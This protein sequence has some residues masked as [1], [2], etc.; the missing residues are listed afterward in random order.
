MIRTPAVAGRFYPGDVDSLMDEVE[1]Y[2]RRNV[3]KSH[4]LGVVAPHAGFMYSGGVAGAVYSRVEIP[5]T[6]ILLG[7]N[8]TGDGPRVSLMSEGSWS[9]PFGSVAIDT[10]LAHEILRVSPMIRHD[11]SAHIYEH[12]LETQIPFM[13][14]FRRDF[15]IVPICLMRVGYEVCEEVSR[16]IVRA[17]TALKRSSVLIV[18]SSDMTHYE[19]HKSASKKDRVAIDLI[20][21]RDPK[22]LYTTVQNEDIT[23]CG[24]IPATVMLLACNEMGAKQC[25]LV[26]YM[27]SGEV[28]GD[29]DSVV[30][31]AGIIVK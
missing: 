1:G 20:L 22:G 13:Q 2:I 8:H 15:K 25:E 5:D 9:M 18:A 27:T 12:C 31:Y 26:K 11:T 14:Y 23:M 24:V 29:L 4:A 21:Q 28:S 19:S 6:V 16:E 30:G 7:P 10:E 17:I 3:A